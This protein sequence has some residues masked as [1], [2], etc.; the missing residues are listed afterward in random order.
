MTNNSHPLDQAMHL[1]LVSEDL[2]Q[3]H[4]HPAYGNMVG[5]F[6]G[7]TRSLA[8]RRETWQ[9]TE[10][11]FPDKKPALTLARADTSKAPEWTRRYDMRPLKGLMI[12]GQQ[13]DQ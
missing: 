8:L 5:P 6:G 4:T 9:S 10:L 11:S 3:G 7:V 13:P 2:W 1:E 12:D